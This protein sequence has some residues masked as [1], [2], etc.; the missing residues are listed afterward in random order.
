M[1]RIV[2]LC[3]VHNRFDSRIFDRTCRSLS[4]IA[5]VFLVTR[6]AHDELIEGVRVSAFPEYRGRLARMTVGSLR[7]FFHALSLRGDVY[8]TISPESMW[9]AL[10]LKLF[11]RAKVAHE[12]HEH[13]WGEIPQ[14]GYLPGWLAGAMVRLNGF[15]QR[16]TFPRLDAIIAATSGIAEEIAPLNPRT[17]TINNYPLREDPPAADPEPALCFLGG[18][19]RDRGAI[20]MLDAI[21]ISK[22]PLLLAGP[23]EPPELEN[24]LKAH[25]GWKF[26]RYQGVVPRRRAMEVLSRARAGIILFLPTAN[27]MRCYS[28]KIFEYMS[29]GLPIIASDFP[30]WR[31]FVADNGCGVMVNPQDPGAVAKAITGLLADPEQAKTMGERGRDRY[32]LEYNWDVEE[33][34]LLDLFGDLL[35]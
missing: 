1:K 29:L 22:T 16:T 33:K 19:T 31:K 15:L 7:L 25:P 6:N 35:G 20:A 24:E 27:N 34:K 5:K 26:V 10:A 28:N 32:R 3:P 13:F 9:V 17:V 11:T 18:I 8:V 4:K 23:I 2:Y 21:A 14:R 30:L 12:V